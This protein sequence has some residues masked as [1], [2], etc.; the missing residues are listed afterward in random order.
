MSKK[1]EN[2]PFVAI[3]DNRDGES[4]ASCATLAFH[5]CP[6]QDPCCS[7]SNS[8]SNEET[9]PRQYLS[10]N[11][12]NMNP[13]N[14]NQATRIFEVQSISHPKSLEHASFFVS[15]RVISNMDL[16]VVTPVDPL[17][18]LLSHFKDE[19]KWQPWDQ[20]VQSKSI[21][22]IVLKGI[23]QDKTQLKHFFEINDSYG[24]DLILYKFKHELVLSWLQKKINR[25]QTFLTLQLDI[26]REKEQMEQRNNIGAFSSSF[27]LSHITEKT[28]ESETSEA[29]SHPPSLTPSSQS[30][31]T[32]NPEDQRILKKSAV[33]IICE[34]LSPFWQTKLLERLE[35]AEGDLHQVK[36]NVGRNESN[37]SQQTCPP[38]THAVT[39]PSS[40]SELS[41]NSQKR[42]LHQVNMSEADKLLQY[43]MGESAGA[44]GE[45]DKGVEAK[46]KKLEAKTSNLKRLEK[47]NTKG[48]KS[49]M[50]F[51]GGATKK[52]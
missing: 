9:T 38:S 37:I 11:E 47:V 31:T 33:Q 32:I 6:L 26:A 43:T 25:I 18:L 2:T 28:E 44:S 24:D 16:H 29:S 7:T 35:L 15:N 34:Y 17:Y 12:P 19:E 27:H 50:S 22:Q 8:T 30:D 36:T 39:P 42:S 20:L 1:R 10:N 46:K 21:P 41:M 14:A 52:K 23:E 48:M 45:V 40:S 49:M 4:K 5:I 51:F 3:I 13:S